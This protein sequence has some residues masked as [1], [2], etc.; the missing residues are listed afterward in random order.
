MT[1]RGNN[2]ASASRPSGVIPLNARCM[3]RDSVSPGLSVECVTAGLWRWKEA[4][5]DTHFTYPYQ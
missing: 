1:W 2:A 4:T 5:G 3:A